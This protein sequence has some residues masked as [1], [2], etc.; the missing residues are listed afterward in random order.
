MT[1]NTTKVQNL[2]SGGNAVVGDYFVGEHTPG[3]TVKLTYAPTVSMDPSPSLAA[4]LNINGKNIIDAASKSLITFTA[5]ASAVNYLNVSNN[6]TGLNPKLSSG[7]TDTNVG[8]DLINQGTGVLNVYTTSDTG[9]KFNTGTANQHSTT[10][11]AANTAASRTITLPDASGTLFFDNGSANTIYLANG[12][13]NGGTWTAVTG[14]GSP[15]LNTSPTLVTPILGTPTSGTLSNCTGYPVANISGLGTGVATWLATPSSANLASALTTKTGTGL[16]V[17]D[18]SPTLVTPALGTPSSGN[19]SS[20]TGYATGNLTGL[21][22]GVAT[23]LATPSSANLLSALT[24]KTGTGTA[25]F[26]TSPTITTPTIASISGNSVSS[27]NFVDGYTTTAT[28]AGTTTLTNASTRNQFFTGT[29]TQTVQMPVTSTLSL[30]WQYEIV[31]N[32]TG[33]VTVNSS[34]ANLIGTVP[35]LGRAILTCVL[36]SGTTA[37]SWYFYCPGRILQSSYATVSGITSNSI[38]N[39]TSLSITPGNWLVSGVIN[40]QNS[41]AVTISNS[42]FC[43][44]STANNTIPQPTTFAT[45]A[46]VGLPFGTTSISQPLYCA[47]APLYVSLSATTTYYLNCLQTFTGTVN[48]IGGLQAV[49]IT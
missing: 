47:T 21:G 39:V 12:T 18:T 9:I 27:N 14:S 40:F 43:A 2:T 11:N 16:A 29:T 48:V 4:N 17:F 15:V 45:M 35:A 24:T 42:T 36:T 25:V 22:S 6:S 3:T 49:E 33:A 1:V 5:V 7:G 30:G 34:G 20:C 19:L 23:W 46:A 38:T 10:I 28:A 13:P 37:A 31:N 44:I 26:D 8:M 32:S 41:G